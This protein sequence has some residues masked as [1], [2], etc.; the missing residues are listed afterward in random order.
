MPN[1]LE[2]EPEAP[3]TEESE[4]LDALTARAAAMVDSEPRR[5]AA[6]AE[7]ALDRARAAHDTPAVFRNLMTVGLARIRLRA[8]SESEGPL[9]E[10]L[11]L[12]GS[13]PAT[14]CEARHG[15]LRATFLAGDHETALEHG[16]HALA[17]AREASDRRLEARSHNDLGLIFGARADYHGALEHLLQGMERMPAE[18]DRHAGSLLNNIGNVYIELGEPDQ[19]LDFFRRAG[20]AFA[21]HGRADGEAIAAGNV[22][23]ALLALDDAAAARESF[24]TSV[25]A[26]EGDGGAAYLAPAVARLAT[27]DAALGRFDEARRGFERACAL[28]DDGPHREFADDVLLAASRFHLERG[29][30]RRAEAL[31]RSALD[32]IPAEEESGRTAALHRAFADT[33]EALGDSA[34]A[35]RHFREFHR[36]REA[37]V[38]GA[39]SL[40]IRGMMR[41]FDVE[42]SRQQE[43]IYRLRNVELARAYEELRALHEQLEAQNRR[44]Q[45]ISVEDSLTGLHNRRYFDEHLL[46]EIARSVRRGRPLTLA[47]CDID[48]FKQVN[49]ELSHA[50]GDD[51]LRM[52]G[53]LFRTTVRQEDLVA[54]Y[55]GEEFAV[56]LPETDLEGAWTLAERLRTRVA[57]YPWH[58]LNPRLAV[59][60]S[61]G[62]AQMDPA[63]ARPETMLASADAM[64]YRAKREGRDRVCG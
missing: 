31:L 42:R 59:T 57:G 6:L 36:I 47:L 26:F 13:D 27:A 45:Q 10:A 63:A 18:D 7:N 24:A 41:Q 49:D 54:R 32:G 33:S 60:L 61:I 16:L 51:V 28:L 20:S 50:V 1:E 64:L 39:A 2:V 34:A 62:V 17:L 35:L 4:G 21:A 15:L 48:H 14:A 58:D 56:I 44:L 3:P 29:D 38:D 53:H 55:G 25:A 11:D 19:A 8:Y 5:A 43:E 12:A 40:R 9:G 22:G 52:M 30:A 46:Q 37:V 23:R